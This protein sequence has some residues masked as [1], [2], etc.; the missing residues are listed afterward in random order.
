MNSLSTQ[1][2]VKN[3]WLYIVHSYP[4]NMNN[5]KHQS[6]PKFGLVIVNWDYYDSSFMELLYPEQDGK[7]MEKTLKTAGYRQIKVV[8]NVRDIEGCVKDYL[9]E[10]QLIEM[11][12]FHIHYSGN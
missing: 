4:L 5:K 7:L 3:S 6:K 10:F 1:D 2:K 8:D 11:E 12:R 9:E